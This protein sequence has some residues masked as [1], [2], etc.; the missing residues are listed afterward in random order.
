MSASGTPPEARLSPKR[1]LKSIEGWERLEATWTKMSHSQAR[2]HHFKQMLQEGLG[3][4]MDEDHLKNM[5]SKRKS[6]RNLVSLEKKS[7]KP[8]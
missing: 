8:L 1:D 5:N 4:N 7:F 6:S 3:H 2:I